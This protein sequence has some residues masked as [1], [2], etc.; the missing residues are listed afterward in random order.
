VSAED[1][2]IQLLE[3]QLGLMRQKLELLESQ[4]TQDQEDVFGFEGHS[5]LLDKLS[6]TQ[7]RIMES[8]G[9]HVRSSFDVKKS[10]KVMQSNAKDTNS[11][12]RVITLRSDMHIDKIKGAH[13]VSYEWI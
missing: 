12:Q 13:I 1:L 2:E 5:N 8:E 10:I 4:V 9:E 11:V 7:E 3:E 6:E